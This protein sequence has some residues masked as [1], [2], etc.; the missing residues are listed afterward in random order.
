MVGG[1]AYEG[2]LRRLEVQIAN[3]AAGRIVGVS[4]AARLE[5]LHPV[6]GVMS[7]RN[8][9]IQQCALMTDRTMRAQNSSAHTLVAKYL[10]ERYDVKDRSR[11]KLRF[12]AENVL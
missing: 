3:I 7:P 4:R 11:E 2:L 5:I 12:P 6:A 9:F 1:S 8:L 10:S